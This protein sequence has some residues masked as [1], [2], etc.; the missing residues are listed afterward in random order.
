MDCALGSIPLRLGVWG[1][2]MFVFMLASSVLGIV[3]GLLTWVT[4]ALSLSGASVL[5]IVLGNGLAALVFLWV[6]LR[7]SGSGKPPKGLVAGGFGRP[8][9]AQTARPERF[10][11]SQSPFLSK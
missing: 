2:V 7:A 1:V 4:G 5:A 8:V 6:L 3:V 9:F 11:L 10:A